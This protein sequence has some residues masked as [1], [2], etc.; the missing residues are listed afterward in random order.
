MT[1]QV[2]YRD[3]REE[4]W[5]GRERR[6]AEDV[7]M[8]FVR[9]WQ[10]HAC[11]LLRRVICVEWYCGTDCNATDRIR[12]GYAWTAWPTAL[13]VV[14]GGV[15]LRGRRL[16]VED[17]G[18]EWR[19]GEGES[20][21]PR[22]CVRAMVAVA[23]AGGHRRHHP[24]PP[25]RGLC[26]N[27]LHPSFPFPFPFHFHSIT[28]PTVITAARRLLPAVACRLRAPA[29]AVAPPAEGLSIPTYT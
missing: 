26:S 20:E 29:P 8:G 1:G 10:C 17:W 24:R 2:R 15:V 19:R 16:E 28:P 27:L 25:D 11:K 3:G 4:G 18:R 21:R 5:K 6:K 7:A 9:S 23:S 13:A 14:C 22:H 12:V